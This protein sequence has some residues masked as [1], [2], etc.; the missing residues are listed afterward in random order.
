MKSY[1]W[2]T[3]FLFFTIPPVFSQDTVR[4]MI[5]TRNAGQCITQPDQT[6]TMLHIKKVNLRSVK[7]ITLIVKGEH[8]RAGV[9]KRDLEISGDESVIVHETRLRPGFFNLSRTSVKKDLLAGKTVQLYMIMN[10]ANNM[11]KIPSRRMFL[12]NL[13]M[14]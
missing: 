4:L 8:T 14:K 13:M 9:Y 3:L 10:P 7:N 5:N 12:V 2:L 6:E 11:M 1:T